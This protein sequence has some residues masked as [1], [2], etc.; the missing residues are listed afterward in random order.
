MFVKSYFGRSPRLMMQMLMRL[1]SGKRQCAV[2]NFFAF[3][4]ASWICVCSLFAFVFNWVCLIAFVNLLCNQNSQMA[5][6][7]CCKLRLLFRKSPFDGLR[8]RTA[9]RCWLFSSVNQTC[10]DILDFCWRWRRLPF[11]RQP[12][13][14]FGPLPSRFN[15]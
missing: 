15:M 13:R 1:L 14:F 11:W 3:G 12:A 10:V 7:R 9:A 2:V 4:G 5:I 8:M 6:A